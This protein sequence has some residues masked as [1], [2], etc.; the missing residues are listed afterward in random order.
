[1]SVNKVDKTT[2]ELLT[3]ANGTRMWIGTQSAHDA[4]VAAG[5][6][7]NNCMVCIT[8]ESNSVLPDWSNAQNITVSTTD[9]EFLEDGWLV[10]AGYAAAGS[11]VYLTIND[12]RIA[13]TDHTANKYL[14]YANIQVMVSKGDKVKVNDAL[15]AQYYSFVPFKK[16]GGA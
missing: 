3:L 8:D 7:P 6:M 12:V 2:G 4:A 11:T 10:G 16:F 1:M 15:G 5:T 9:Y 14:N 13:A